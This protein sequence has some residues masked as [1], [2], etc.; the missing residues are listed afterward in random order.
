VAP[1]RALAGTLLLAWNPVVLYETW[2]NGHND[3]AMVFWVL[4][5]VCFLAISRYRLAA[6]AL[7]VGMLVK[8][9]PA[10]L[11]PAAGIIAIVHLK[12]WRG[13]LG[14]LVITGLAGLALIVLAYAPFWEGSEILTVN[15]RMSLFTTTLPSAL[16]NFLLPELGEKRA[17]SIISLGALVLTALFTIGQSLLAWRGRPWERFS[18]AAFSI[19]AFYL[20]FTN[21]WFQQWYTLWPIGLAPF[22]SGNSR[23]LAILFGFAALSKQLFIGPLLFWGPAVIEQPWKELWFTLGTLGLPLAYILVIA[24]SESWKWVRCTLTSRAIV[25]GPPG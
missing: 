3:M 20:L 13:R 15:R 7:V 25:G 8:Y 9:I 22:V 5:A 23:R 14:F 21:L 16:F 19:L 4:A 11:F 1:E 24:L 18:Q 10:L 6:L 17:A 12:T 2:G